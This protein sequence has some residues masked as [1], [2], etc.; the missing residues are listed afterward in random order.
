MCSVGGEGP[1]AA[2]QPQA[3]GGRRRAETARPT[4]MGRPVPP[5]VDFHAMWSPEGRGD[6]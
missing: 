6:L 1:D 5:K 3:A 4:S 2:Q